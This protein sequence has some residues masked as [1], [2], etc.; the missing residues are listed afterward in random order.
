MGKYKPKDQKFEELKKTIAELGEDD[1]C[2]IA[3][4]IMRDQR[5]D[6]FTAANNFP[7]ND[8]PITRSHLSELIHSMY[9]AEVEKEYDLSDQNR[10]SGPASKIKGMLE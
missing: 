3:V 7:T 6:T 4:S 10:T 5:V 9:E 8:F 2:V 1:K